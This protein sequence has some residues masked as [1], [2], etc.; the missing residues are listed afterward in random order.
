MKR[1]IIIGALLANAIICPTRAF[2]MSTPEIV[3]KAKKSVV[4]IKV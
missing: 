1:Y 3:A 2:A 4:T